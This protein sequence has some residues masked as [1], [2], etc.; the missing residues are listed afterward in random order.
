MDTRPSEIFEP[1]P[2]IPPVADGENRPFWSVMIPTYNCNHYLVEA[3]RS[4]L[5][6]APG[7]EEMQICVVDDNSPGWQDAH[8]IAM[9][10]GGGRVDFV[11]G[12]ENLGLAGNWNRCITLSRGEAVH[13]LHQDDY[14]L[15]GF[16]EKLQEG[17]RQHPEIGMAFCRH[18]K[19]YEQ[20]GYT[21]FGPLEQ[22][23]P[24]ILEGWVER[25]LTKPR[26]QC[27]SVTV[28]RSTYET[29]GGFL[30]QLVYSVD[31][32]MW[33]RIAARFAVWYEPAALACYRWH[34]E[35]ESSR[36]SRQKNIPYD[37]K[38]SIDIMKSYLTE[39]KYAPYFRLSEKNR[40]LASS[41]HLAYELISAGKLREGLDCIQTARRLLPWF[42]WHRKEPYL[43]LAKGCLSWIPGLRKSFQACKRQ[44]YR[45]RTISRQVQQH[46]DPSPIELGYKCT[47]R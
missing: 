3:I 15:P 34:D 2:P 32:E 39:D 29:V 6:Q 26:M 11:R 40:V 19:L 8:D 20:R 28:R 27:A 1:P 42:G 18:E 10:E 30:P 17:F 43:T 25:L 9:A 24:G 4:V 14:V 46:P 12:D 35:S 45:T 44:W 5:R 23:Q 16:Y 47:R 7:E 21:T 31:E 13:I 36:L 22:D 37:Q 41:L 33:V 38:R